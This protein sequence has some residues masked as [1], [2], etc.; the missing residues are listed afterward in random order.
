[1]LLWITIVFLLAYG[2]LLLFYKRAWDHTE[3]YVIDPTHEQTFISVIIPARN[4]ESNIRSLL[5]S[6]QEQSYPKELFEIIVVDDFS[7][8]A[9]ASVVNSFGLI[10]LHLISPHGAGDHSSKKKAIEAGISHARGELIVTTDADCSLPVNWLQTIS[11]FYKNKKAS[12][13]AAPVKFSHDNSLLQVFQAIDFMTLQG[14]T[15]ASV[16]SGFHN[17]CNGANLAYRKQSFEEVKGFAG[18]D[19]VASGDDM[20][21]MHKIWKREPGYVYYLKSKEAIVRTPPMLSWKAFYNQRKRWASK[22]LVYEDYRILSVLAFIYL[23]NC[24]F[25]V[26]LIA[27]AWHPVN[28]LYALG[29]LL[30][31]MLIE[32]P[33]I[34]SVARF[35]EEQKIMKYFPLFQPLHVIYTV[36]VGFT[37][38]L[39]SYEWKGRRTK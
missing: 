16:T 14:I 23:F 12:F 17:M 3:E 19:K 34:H 33:F 39:G 31:K 21:L 18:I 6:L 1:M 38:Q 10:N 32:Y 29:F 15:A 11:S 9:T 22:T 20:L 4:E 36:V 28:A 30:V 27:S 5:T 2:G 7:T 24:L 13:I 37:S 25:F 8:D 26:L 35:Y